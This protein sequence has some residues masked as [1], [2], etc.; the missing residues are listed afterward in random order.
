MKRIF[1]ALAAFAHFGAATAQHAAEA[2]KKDSFSLARIFSDG[3]LHGQIRQFSMRTDNAAGLSDYFAV[4]VGASMQYETRAWRGWQIEMGGDFVNDIASSDFTKPDPA[5][6][7]FDRY[8]A[9]LYE[10]L[11]LGDKNNVARL[12]EL[13]VRHR[14]G[15]FEA[16]FGKQKIETPLV[17]PQDGRMNPTLMEGL[18][19]RGDFFGKKMRADAGWLYRSSPRSTNRWFSLSESMG[20]Y[21]MGVNADGKR[22]DYRGN[23]R[24][25]GLFVLSARV[26]TRL[27][28]LD[29][30]DFF[31]QNVQNT[32]FFQWEKG[33]RL[34]KNGDGPQL[35]LG[36]QALAQRT[37][38]DG[39][40]ADGALAYVQK[41]WRSRAAGGFLAV[42]GGG[43]RGQINA[44][45]IGREGP[46]L[47]PRGGGREPFL[48]IFARERHEGLGDVWG[49]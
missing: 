41:K 38:G 43:R 12:E 18:W 13:L 34:K 9:G 32:A 2:E 26:E 48:T 49:V 10:V 17:N 6:G 42:A 23:V 20:V 35:F 11:E 16:I 47:F 22:N 14:S 30:W 3:H 7:A 44:T 8:D 21:S 33:F 4:A 37:A 5:T 27:G 1:L 39:G 29:F 24:T 31:L 15:R 36:A 25:A 28:K 40:N 46:F 19:L 45:R